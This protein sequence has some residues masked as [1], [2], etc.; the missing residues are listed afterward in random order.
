MFTCTREISA[1]SC[2]QGL[3]L[4]VFMP[5]RSYAR[6]CSPIVPICVHM[7]RSLVAPS[8]RL[9]LK[10]L[11][12]SLRGFSFIR[13]LVLLNVDCRDVSSK[14]QPGLL[15]VTVTMYFRPVCEKQ[16]SFH[17]WDSLPRNTK[18]PIGTLRCRCQGLARTHAVHPCCW[19]AC[20]F[21]PR[22]VF[23]SDYAST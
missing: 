20:V 8:A 21:M 13:G 2:V 11:W 1:Q 10:C 19:T 15:C 17:L 6:L 18:R 12:A 7:C 16:L 14:P 23:L 5:F 4:F 22:N 3:S 9:V